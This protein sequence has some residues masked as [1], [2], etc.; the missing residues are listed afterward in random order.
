MCV[1]HDDIRESPSCRA[2]VVGFGV[3]PSFAHDL[4]Q[5]VAV[6]AFDRSKSSVRWVIRR[7]IAT[8]IVPMMEGDY[9]PKSVM[10]SQGSCSLA[11]MLDLHMTFLAKSPSDEG[12]ILI[13]ALNAG[14]GGLS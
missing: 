3:S 8:G 4:V 7:P 12:S 11:R 10:N 14:Q 13:T 2:R 9:I 5:W 6:P 1:T